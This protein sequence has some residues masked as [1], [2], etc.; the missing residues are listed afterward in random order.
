M[1]PRHKGDKSGRHVTPRVKISV[2]ATLRKVFE[3]CAKRECM[4][5]SAWMLEAAEARAANL[6]FRSCRAGSGETC[7][8]DLCKR[9]A[10]AAVP[11]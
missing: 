6:L 9:D 5:L 2:P 8:C 4:T 11:G 7:T 3:E 1:P 10:I